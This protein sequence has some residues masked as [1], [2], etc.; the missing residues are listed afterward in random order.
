MTAIATDGSMEWQRA[1]RWK[2]AGLLCAKLALLTLLWTLF[3]S[4][5]HRIAVD[6]VATSERFG[7]SD[8]QSGLPANRIPSEIPT[9]PEKL[10]D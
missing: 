9:Q 5:S 10:R 3:F 6:S 4:P 8:G 7:I 2:I 1:M